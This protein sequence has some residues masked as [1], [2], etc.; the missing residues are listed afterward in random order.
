MRIRLALPHF[1]EAEPKVTFETL[2]LECSRS[3]AD[4]FSKF[5]SGWM[6]ISMGKDAHD[7]IHRTIKNILRDK[8][9]FSLILFSC[10]FFL[11]LYILD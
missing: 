8:M 5:I 4:S 10:L 3:E 7:F 9:A 11:T 2:F 1:K 6:K